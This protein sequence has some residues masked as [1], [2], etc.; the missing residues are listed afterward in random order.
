MIKQQKVVNVQYSNYRNVIS[1]APQDRVRGPLLF[2]LY[3]HDMWFGFENVL[4]AYADD[5]SLFASVPSS[6]MR[7]QIAESLNINL[8]R[9]NVLA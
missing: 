5:A 3:T 1:G 6:G 4:V 2:I 8:A 7:R 9:V